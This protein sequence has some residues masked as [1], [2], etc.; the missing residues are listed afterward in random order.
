[1]YAT[2]TEKG[3][4]L[5]SWKKW[6]KNSIIPHSWCSCHGFRIQVN[7]SPNKNNKST[8]PFRKTKISILPYSSHPGPT[9]QTIGLTPKYWLMFVPSWEL[10]PQKNGGV[11]CRSRSCP[12][13]LGFIFWMVWRLRNTR[14]RESLPM[15]H[16]C[17][18]MLHGTGMFT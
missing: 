3:G 9:Y 11:I 7:T 1:M 13:H 17:T 10:I 2:Q 8:Q 16:P 4:A 18:Q 15:T 5:L 6:T 12:G 14:P